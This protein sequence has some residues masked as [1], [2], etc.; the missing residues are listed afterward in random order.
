MA[1]VVLEMESSSV[2]SQ[3]AQ[4][5]GPQAQYSEP[6]SFST[7]IYLHIPFCRS[8]CS[9]CDFNTYV[10]LNDLFEPYVRALQQE[11][12]RTAETQRAL[13]GSPSPCHPKSKIETIFF[14]G[15]TPSLLQP[16]WIGD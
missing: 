14:G 12:I 3:S 6:Q 8:R 13:Q 5:T 10:G 2:L 4:G 7:G 16:G 11:I 9:Y 1:N 15:G